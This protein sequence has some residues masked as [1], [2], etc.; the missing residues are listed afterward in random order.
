MRRED[1]TPTRDNALLT[2]KALMESC[3]SLHLHLYLH[4]HLHLHLHLNPRIAFASSR[5]QT[6]ARTPCQLASSSGGN[7]SLSV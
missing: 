2:I 4:L 3:A 7:T 1:Q 6:S 5:A